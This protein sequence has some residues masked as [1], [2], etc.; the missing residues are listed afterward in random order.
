MI[1]KKKAGQEYNKRLPGI[2][3]NMLDISDIWI[4]EFIR[5]PL[6]YQLI[7]KAKVFCHLRTNFLDFIWK[8]VNDNHLNYLIMAG[9]LTSVHQMARDGNSNV[10]MT[11]YHVRFHP[12]MADLL[13]KGPG[14]HQMGQFFGLFKKTDLKKSK[15][16]PIW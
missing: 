1:E 6:N 10:F 16:Y 3:R 12:G 9:G 5:F 13:P 4:Q 11:K 8:C 2:N 14:W 7:S 15:T